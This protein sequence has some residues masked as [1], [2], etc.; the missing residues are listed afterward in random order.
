MAASL[1]F[2]TK[3]NQGIVGSSGLGFYGANFAASVPVGEY[4]TTTFITN[5]AGTAQGPACDNF[6]YLN[7]QSGYLNSA[8]SGI[9]LWSVPNAEATFRIQFTNDTAVKTQNIQLR[10]YDRTTITSPMSGTLV[11]IAEVRHPD[12]IQT[13]TGSGTAVWV[14]WN[15]VTGVLS[16]TAGV[17]SGGRSQGPNTIDVRHDW[18]IVMSLSPNEIGSK[19]GAVYCSLEYL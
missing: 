17:G 11:K 14:S 4:Q 1:T 18:F 9:P 3:N 7:A 16:L 15:A 10:T 5:A 12:P 6:K 13:H 2:W 19:L 8:S